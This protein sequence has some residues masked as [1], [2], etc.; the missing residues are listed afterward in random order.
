MLHL[1]LTSS[2]GNFTVIKRKGSARSSMLLD[3]G[4]APLAGVDFARTLRE[5]FSLAA[6]LLDGMWKVCYRARSEAKWRNRI[7]A[8]E[9]GLG[10]G[11]N[12]TKDWRA[13][14]LRGYP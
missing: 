5:G 14:L 10:R 1:A 8:N 6:D 7:L 2:I 11:I 12:H 3:S 9:T 13:E 4:S